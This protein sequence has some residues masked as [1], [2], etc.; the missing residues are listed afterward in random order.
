MDVVKGTCMDEWSGGGLM[1]MVG[2]EKSGITLSL[3]V[4][5]LMNLSTTDL[6]YMT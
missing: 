5:D 3:W 4:G 1:S 6:G 2:K